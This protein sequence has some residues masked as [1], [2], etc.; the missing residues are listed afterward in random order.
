MLNED[1]GRINMT[2]VTM[3][4]KEYESMKNNL[5]RLK[6]ES[7]YRFAQRKSIDLSKDQYEVVINVNEIMDYIAKSERKPVM[8]SV[9]QKEILTNTC[10][11]SVVVN[12]DTSDEDDTQ[13]VLEQ[14][15]DAILRELNISHKLS[16]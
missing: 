15:K 7:I 6:K 4:I 11:P 3:P 12:I 1:Q 14:V 8:F 5:E 13:K 9:I 10:S 16:R 2:T